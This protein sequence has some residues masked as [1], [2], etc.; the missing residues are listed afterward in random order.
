MLH[1]AGGS[2]TKFSTSYDSNPTD[3]PHTFRLFTTFGSPILRLRTLIKFL[4]FRFQKLIRFRLKIKDKLCVRLIN[5]L[6]LLAERARAHFCQS[7]FGEGKQKSSQTRV[8]TSGI[9]RLTAY[10]YKFR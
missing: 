10:K 9:C 1:K 3:F 6:K 2:L 5:Y 7:V 8:V 4:S